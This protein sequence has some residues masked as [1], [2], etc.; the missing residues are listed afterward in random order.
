MSEAHKQTVLVTGSS[1]CLG[2]HVVR[3]LHEN[4]D[5]VGEIRCFDIK[6]YQ[7]N[8]QHK[9]V[10]EMQI[11]TADIRNERQLI[12]AMKDVDVVIHCA[13]LIDLGFYQNKSELQSVNVEGTQKV[14]DA[15]VECN[16]P[17]LVHISGADVSIGSDP[18][19]YGSE[20][21]TFIPKKHLLGEYS[22]SKYEAEQIVTEANGRSL[23]NG[24][25]KLQTVVLR[26]TW[27]YGE[28][29][30]NFLT[31]ILGVAKSTGGVL[32]R[33]DN[34]FIRGQPVYAGNVACACLR[35]KDKLQVD[36]SVGGEHFFI[37]D[38][39]KIL[40]PFEFVE[41][42]VKAKGFQLSAR[43]YPFWL[44]VLILSLY[45][46]LINLLW[47][48]YPI[49]LPANLTTAN[50]RF[51]CTTYFFNRTKA[52]LRLDY[53]PLYEHEESETRSLQYY[54]KVTI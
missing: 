47:S 36:P 7:N 41:P 6:P 17:Y 45:S 30:N 10:K 15:A 38:D 4:D 34:V 1:G 12:N 39:T 50:V 33:I 13:A 24:S 11:T 51:L 35:A 26:P 14:I 22:K 52:T 8:M 23:S 46:W 54:K 16:V 42:Y 29:D 18:I 49:K 40:D 19:Y 28:E 53:E 9:I 5:T 2:Q 21:T 48:V 27:I 44:F 20:N 32:R 43:A 25:Q 37:T 3:L 31:K